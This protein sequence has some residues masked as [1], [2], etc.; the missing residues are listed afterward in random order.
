MNIYAE[1][2]AVLRWLLNASRGD[3][4]HAALSGATAVFA[5]RLTLI[6][7]R[8]GLLRAVANREITEEVSHRAAALL[9]TA[10]ASWSIVEMVPEIGERAARPFPQEPIRSLDALHLATA[11]YLL[12]EIGPVAILSTDHRILENAPLL[13]LPLALRSGRA[14]GT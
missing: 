10:V 7:T 4:V 9:A 14:S 1:S 5:S 2:S 12:P 13:G 11:L 8:R 6:E 3:E